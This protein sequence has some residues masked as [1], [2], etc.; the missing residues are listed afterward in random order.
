[1]SSIGRNLLES[2]QDET[3]EV[4]LE[5]ARLDQ[6]L[7][8]IAESLPLPVDVEDLFNDR[9]ASTPSVH[10]YGLIGTVKEE[11]WESI[12]ILLKASQADESSLRQSYRKGQA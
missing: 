11:L 9:V 8:R 12:T 6:R 1:M 3:L 2:C 5:L 4:A 10:L 7:A